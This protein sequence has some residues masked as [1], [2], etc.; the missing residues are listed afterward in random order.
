[1]FFNLF[2]SLNTLKADF[3]KGLPVYNKTN[4]SRFHADSVCKASVS[5]DAFCSVLHD[6]AVNHHLSEYSVCVFTRQLWITFSGF[7]L[8]PLTV[9]LLCLTEQKAVSISAYTRVSLR[10]EWV[11]VW[12]LDEGLLYSHLKCRPTMHNKNESWC[13]SKHF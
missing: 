12:P 4:F 13:V 8:I 5:F 11:L 10:T 2:L 6:W 1:M 7:V 3:L 9:H